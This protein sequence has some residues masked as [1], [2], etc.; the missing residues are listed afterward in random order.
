MTVV[1]LAGGKSSRMGQDKLLLPYEGEALLMRAVRRYSARFPNVFV[2]VA[3][4]AKYPS[5]AERCISDL[6][7]GCGPISGLEAALRHVGKPV[8]LTAGDMPFSSPDAAWKLR[9]FLSDDADI[10]TL[11][12]ADGSPE[13]LFAWY[14]PSVLPQIE[15]QLSEQRHSMRRLLEHCRSVSVSASELG[16][17]DSARMLM[18]VNNREEYRRLLLL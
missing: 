12:D 14:K 15:R 7:P 4:A 2:S 16:L 3:D 13:P 8:F 17:S 1:L 10:C 5:L 9:S 11:T 6:H 18:N